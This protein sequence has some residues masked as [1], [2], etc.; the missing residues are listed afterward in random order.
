[1][2]MRISVDEKDAGWLAHERL[3]SERK[4][5]AIL[6]DGAQQRG[7]ITADEEAGEILRVARDTDGYIIAEGDN[8]KTEI[9]RGDVMV[10]VS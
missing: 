5:I 9:V 3:L 8:A 1:M 2:I 4:H 6:L 10:V 7:V